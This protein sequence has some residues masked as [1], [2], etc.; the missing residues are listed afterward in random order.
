MKQS[1]EQWSS[2]I[3]FVMA[4]AGSAIGLG[5]LWRF[6]YVAGQNGG[7]IFVL[8][9][10][11]FT[12]VI[13]LPIF[14]AE[15]IVGRRTQKSAVNAY[16]ELSHHSSNWRLFG[17]FN[18]IT[19]F[20]VLSYYCIVSGWCINYVF[21]SL[22]HFNV[23]H[24]AQEISRVFD[25]LYTSSDI[26]LFWSFLFILMNVGIVSGGLKKGIEHWARVLT[27]ALFLLFLALFGFSLSLDGFPAAFRFVF[28]PDF[29]KL[30]PSSILS[31]LGMSFYT[32]SVGVGILATYGSYMKSSD[33]LPKT[34]LTVSCMTLLIS[35]MSA[36]IVFPITF[37]FGM[38]AAHG[39]GLVFKT[40]PT[41]FA[42]LPGTLLLSTVF[43]TLLG[44]MTLTSSISLFEV[45]VTNL[46]ETLRWSRKKAIFLSA[47]A[48]WILG[49]PS[50]MAGS[51]KGLFRNWQSMFGMDFFSTLDY[52]TGNWMLP[53]GALIATLFVGWRLQRRLVEEEFMQGAKLR[54]IFAIWAFLLRW[55]APSAII[56]ILMQEGGL[57]DINALFTGKSPMLF[58]LLGAPVALGAGL[59]LKRLLSKKDPE[60]SVD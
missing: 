59:G 36:L 19:T 50:A 6:P 7:G 34:G 12:L 14:L 53:C 58:V 30:T 54:V 55:I 4:A 44:F 40:L 41:L 15:L 26:N 38:E 28:S 13:S 37:T 51:G 31:A 60:P 25:T 49:V 18:V 22:S 56:V 45:L 47:A 9:Y 52:L 21:L 10:L 17:W 39:P 16:F 3:G 29:S 23:G 27:P 32:L 43:F 46:M 11:L 1:R 24:T 57:I 42:Q 8:L 48:V 35:L 33:N 20:L 2:K 5:C